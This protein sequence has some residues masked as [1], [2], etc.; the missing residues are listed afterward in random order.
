[1]IE[2]ASKRIVKFKGGLGNQIF[3]YAFFLNLK[4]NHPNVKIDISSYDND[5]FELDL[6]FNCIDLKSIATSEELDCSRDIGSF[7]RVRKWIGIIFFKNPN[8]FIRKSHFI[9]PFATGF[10]E[11]LSE[12]QES[13][14]DGYWQ[15]EK[16][17]KNSQSELLEI[18]KFDNISTESRA[19]ELKMKQGNSVALHV[20][21]RDK[22]SSR[23]NPIKFT[24]I[25]LTTR[26]CSRRYYGHAMKYIQE[27]VDEPV[28]YI[29]SND[30][31]WA[32]KNLKFSGE[33]YFVDCNQL[34][35]WHEDMYLM[36]KCKHNIISISSFSWWSA[37]INDDPSQIVIAPKK[38]LSRREI[39]PDVIPDNWTQ[40]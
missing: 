40:I 35:N 33:Y 21:R 8:Q 30:I 4:K 10:E 7:I 36:S 37:W 16:Y 25:A 28:F 19:Y 26:I 2:D 39:K 9:Q 12:R 23:W 13:Y 6:I 38:W 24:W 32:K 5:S 1:M 31:K 34:N 17:F 3:Q 14:F 29:F 18:L 11:S 20:R 22:G 27:N 15:N